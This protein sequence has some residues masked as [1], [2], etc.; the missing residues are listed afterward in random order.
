MAEKLCIETTF[1]LIA[2]IDYVNAISF[3]SDIRYFSH[4]S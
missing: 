1:R 3:Y 2:T 4:R